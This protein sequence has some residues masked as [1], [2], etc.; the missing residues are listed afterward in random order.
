[1]LVLHIC[2]PIL[3][4]LRAAIYPTSGDVVSWLENR[5]DA[6]AGRP[7]R[8]LEEVASVTERSVR[9][10]GIDSRHHGDTSAGTSGEGGRGGYAAGG[11]EGNREAGR[12]MERGSKSKNGKKGKNSKTELSTQ[13]SRHG[14]LAL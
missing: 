7:L 2:V 10:Y 8:H 14:G 4:C 13:K 1:M 3:A 5:F 9:S 6:R 12:R 11:G